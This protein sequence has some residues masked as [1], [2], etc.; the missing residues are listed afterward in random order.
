MSATPGRMTVSPSPVAQAL[1]ENGEGDVKV[2]INSGGGIATEGMAIYSLLKAHPGKVAMA[3][4]GVAASAASLIAMAGDVRTMRDGAMMMI[5]DPATIT[6]GNATHARQE[7]RLPR[8]ARQQLRR[9]LWPRL[10]QNA[11]RCAQDHEGRKA[12]T[13]P[14]RRCRGLCHREDGRGRG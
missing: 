4:D 5:H 10:G 9:R 11:G 13:P 14:M 7:R 6:V 8:Q 3:I 2:R 1:A 12:G